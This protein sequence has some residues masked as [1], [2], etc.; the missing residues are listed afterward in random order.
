M[1]DGRRRGGPFPQRRTDE[2]S[3]V[4]FSCSSNNKNK[5]KCSTALQPGKVRGRL[6]EGDSPAEA[7]GRDV[8]DLL[9]QTCVL[10]LLLA[11]HANEFPRRSYLPQF[12]EAT[13]PRKARGRTF[14]RN[15]LAEGALHTAEALRKVS[16]KGFRHFKV[17]GNSNHHSSH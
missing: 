2:V 17:T 7:C 10:L 5:N 11:N 9:F 3:G 1:N 15:M 16:R 4:F 14:Y 6:A 12:P 8:V 13:C